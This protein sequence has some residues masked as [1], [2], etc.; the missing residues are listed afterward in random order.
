M[1]DHRRRRNAPRVK[2]L[3]CC[4]LGDEQRRQCQRWHLQTLVERVE[5]VAGE[6]KL[7]ELVLQARLE[8]VETLVDC[9]GVHRFR[10]VQIEPHAGVLGATAGHHEG[11]RRLLAVRLPG[12]AC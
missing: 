11:D 5:I 1:A 2:Q 8:Q 12:D 4:P 9:I 10:A 3:G 6:Q 7:G